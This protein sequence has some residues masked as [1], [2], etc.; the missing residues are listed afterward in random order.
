M[1]LRIPYVIAYQSVDQ[2]ENVLVRLSTDRGLFGFGCAAPD[3][4]VT[5]ESP[6]SVVKVI[7]EE[8]ADLVRG[9]D[10]TMPVQ[11][12]ERLR[13]FL[14]KHPSAMAAIDMALYDLLGK[15]AGLPLYK[16]LGGFQHRILTSITIGILSPEETVKQALAH[17]ASGFKS[18]K[19]KGGKGVAQDIECVHRVREAV[20]PEIEIRFD[21][22]QG[23][24]VDQA[25]T[26]AKGVLDQDVSLLE[27]PTP[28]Q[29]PD[30]LGRVT[31]GCDL[32]VMADESLMNL[33]D[34]FRLAQGDLVDMVNVKLMKVGGINEAL[35]ISAVARAANLDVMVGCMD[36]AA[37][38]IAAG[39]HYA[40]ARPQVVYADLDGSLDLDNDPTTGA[41]I[42]KDG[43]LYPTE[44]PGL[45]FD[46]SH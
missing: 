42:L 8:I 25:L 46:P 6:D 44:R 21:A 43:Y 9:G 37:L 33:R 29:S 4:E 41:V 32:R 17:K 36:E 2:A 7:T 35:H 30:L 11:I 10:P 34:A 28:V 18:L 40:L 13:P 27:Q 31:H 22:N 19:I 23:Y 3:L 24:S 45:G 15:I 16:L 12:L 26:F 14:A 39:L 20:G 38:A 5:G 1:P